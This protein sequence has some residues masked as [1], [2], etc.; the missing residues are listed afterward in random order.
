M[1]FVKILVF[2]AFSQELLT[3]DPS[4]SWNKMSSVKK[5]VYNIKGIQVQKRLKKELFDKICQK[6]MNFVDFWN[7]L[8]PQPITLDMFCKVQ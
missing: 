2:L 6:K 5:Y 8:S 4:L 3:F 1:I 7:L